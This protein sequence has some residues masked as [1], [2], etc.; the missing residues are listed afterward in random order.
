[1]F[2]PACQFQQNV[3]M[4]PYTYGPSHNPM[5]A[6]SL[7]SE[8]VL[9][10]NKVLSKFIIIVSTLTNLFSKQLQF[11]YIKKKDIVWF[12]DMF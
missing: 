3:P 10:L 5:P 11:Q 7:V 2:N 4:A 6:V 9:K 1:M 12:L 8:F